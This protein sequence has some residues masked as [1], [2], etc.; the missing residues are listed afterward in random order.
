M[1]PPS[2]PVTARSLLALTLALTAIHQEARVRGLQSPASAPEMFLDGAALPVITPPPSPDGRGCGISGG[3]L[4]R[5]SHAP[6][7]PVPRVTLVSL[8]RDTYE[9]GTPFL[10]EV[11]VEN[12]TPTPL[13]VGA[14]RDYTL[15]YPTSGDC[16]SP[17]PRT[18]VS[19][20]VALVVKAHGE[21][22][23]RR[24]E[25]VSGLHL[26]GDDAR[27]P[28]SVLTIPPGGQLRV[29]VPGEWQFLTSGA[30]RRLRDDAPTSFQA[31]AVLM[32]SHADVVRDVVYSDNE[33]EVWLARRGR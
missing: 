10:A 14:T 23:G 16:S 2:A 12:T 6:P 30:S 5:S 15:K 21:A 32:V 28:G 4:G 11:L 24:G 8:D 22:Q 1:I 20:T 29:R 26:F 27:A 18:L 25:L 13:H 9:L 31:G 33:L 3:V 17:S 7:P 19:T